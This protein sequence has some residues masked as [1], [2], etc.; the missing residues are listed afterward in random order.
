V[1]FDQASKKRREHRIDQVDETHGTH[2][3]D[4]ED[5]GH[6]RRRKKARI[7]QETD[8]MDHSTNGIKNVTL[9][10]APTSED[11]VP[12]TTE[13]ASS[14]DN[15][16]EGGTLQQI[17]KMPSERHAL[18]LQTSVARAPVDPAIISPFI[19]L[20]GPVS[21]ELDNDD[22]LRS[23]T[24]VTN[25]GSPPIDQPKIPQPSPESDDGSDYS[26]HVGGFGAGFPRP[27]DR[28]NGW[29]MP[30][31]DGRYTRVTL[32]EPPIDEPLE[33]VPGLSRSKM[34]RYEEG[35]RRIDQ[36]EILQARP[37][38]GSGRETLRGAE[39]QDDHVPTRYYRYMNAAREE[40][41][42]PGRGPGLSRSK[43]RRY[44]ELRNRSDVQ[45]T[46][47][48]TVESVYDPVYSRAQKL[49]QVPLYRE[50]GQNRSSYYSRPRSRYG[51][52]RNDPPVHFDHYANPF[53]RRIVDTHMHAINEEDSGGM[54]NSP[55]A[56]SR[57]QAYQQQL[58]Q[59][60]R[61]MSQIRWQAENPGIDNAR[62]SQQ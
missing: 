24:D 28:P 41:H 62:P 55:P 1:W 57:V 44:E 10:V 43:K 18:N 38:R 9:A 47:Q 39:P 53:E 5:A 45:D 30:F 16:A 42:E 2:F 59:Q 50:S 40:Q 31:R 21:L 27:R 6:Q 56:L 7:E 22:D 11:Q 60:Q 37:E 32:N 19:A 4:T 58:V 51:E 52:I 48:P 29:G 3:S 35:R 33:R 14:Q 46:P 8:A 13:E 34:R 25:F 26:T 61:M 15:A 54:K 23:V 49:D 17:S 12:N 20:P 36:Q